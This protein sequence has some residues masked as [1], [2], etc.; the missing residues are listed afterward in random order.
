MRRK[1]LLGFIVS[2]LVI[3]ST[4]NVLPRIV[5]PETVEAQV[6]SPV[7]LHPPFQFTVGISPL[8]LPSTGTAIR[9]VTLKAMSPGQTIYIGTSNALTASSGFPLSDGDSIGIEVNNA[10]QIYVMATANNQR[11]AVLAY[12]RQ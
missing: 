2:A 9:G 5:G 11:L 10:N 3:T 7:T 8:P 6:Y 12:R 4:P 1:L